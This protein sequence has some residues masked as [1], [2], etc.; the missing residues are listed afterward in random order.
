MDDPIVQEVRQA[1]QAYAAR[2]NYDLAAMV[3]D[4]QRRTEEAR[5]AGREVVALPPRHL[6]PETE[7]EIQSRGHELAPSADPG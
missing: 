6:P 7:Y 4:L 5:R 2:F 1:R 3:A